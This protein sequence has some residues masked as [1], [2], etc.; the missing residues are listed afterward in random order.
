MQKSRNTMVCRSPRLSVHAGASCQA[1]LRAHRSSGQLFAPHVIPI[2]QSAILPI[3]DSV[4]LSIYP[5]PFTSD[6]AISIQKEDLKQATFTITNPLGQIIYTQQ[7]NNLS[8]NY[9]K[10]LDLSYLPAGIYFVIV[11]AGGETVTR[12][13]IKE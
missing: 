12:E 5:N 10:M 3:T 2:S 6:I 4:R 9:T 7:E 13:V 1:F 11:N 8:P